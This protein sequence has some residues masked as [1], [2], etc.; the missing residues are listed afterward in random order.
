MA[1]VAV[2]GAGVTGLVAA[3]RLAQG[4]DEVVV[5]E[6]WPGLGGMAATLDVGGGHRL[7]RYYHHWFTSDR[8]VLALC[9][10]LGVA[11]DWLPSSVG[12]YAGGVLH[13]FTTP[14]DLLR[15]SPLPPAT[16]LRMGLAVVRLQRFG[17]PSE[18]YEGETA[19][20]WVRAHMGEQAWTRV[21]EPLMRAKFG[22]RAE[23]ISM[24]WLHSKLT[25]RRQVSGREA[26]GEV[27]GYPR[28]S[29]E[30]LFAALEQ[31][32]VRAGG[33]VWIDRPAARIA[34]AGDGFAV[35]SGAPGSFRS[36]HDP[37]AFERG[38]ED[39]RF[40]AVLATVPGEVFNTLLDDRLADARVA[41]VEHRAALCLLLEVD[42]RVLPYYWNNIGDASDLRFLGAVE[43]TNLVEPARYDGRRFLYLANYLAQDDP[44]LALGPDE[45]LAAYEP[46]LRRLA[47]SWSSDRIR[48][49]WLFR[50]PDAQ[51]VVDVGYR[52]RIPSLARPVPGLVLANMAQVWPEDRGTNYA[53]RLAADAVAALVH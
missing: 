39:E 40:D 18:A 24:S 37:R 11:L 20:A 45:L 22:E 53:V 19:S 52:A 34:R 42:R 33:A 1:R 44:L 9:E 28:G 41:P 48:E 43:H 5:Y 2:I 30:A 8:H 23:E 4:G 21:W 47:G 13:P 17:P 12:F 6:R 29:F 26:R 38:G 3:L 15:F 10:E 32:I 46:G 31:A 16:R 25:V 7:E 51:P 27:L 36:G 35:T 49:R 50:E 14:L